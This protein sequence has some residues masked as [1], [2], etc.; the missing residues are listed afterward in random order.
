MGLYKL[1]LPYF[2]GNFLQELSL[3]PQ[4]ENKERDP[5][6]HRKVELNIILFFCQQTN[7]PKP[8]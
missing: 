8:L 3:G 1:S 4:N 6:P 5:P 7:L 2:K